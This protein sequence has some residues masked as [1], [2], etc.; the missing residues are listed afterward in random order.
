MF[1]ISFMYEGSYL[2]IQYNKQNIHIEDSYR[3][4]SKRDMQRIL[5][6]VEYASYNRGIFYAR[7]QSSW[8]RE[9]KA[10]NFL[11]KI[12]YKREQVKNVDLNESE[13]LSKR[14]G[15]F[16]LSLFS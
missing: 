15:Y 6:I 8:I 12:N 3:V 13:P 5:S 14:I 9:W 4:K 16:F 7:S 1:S 11:Y 2:H 10:H